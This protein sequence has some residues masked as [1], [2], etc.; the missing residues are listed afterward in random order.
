MW[1]NAEI[2]ILNYVVDIITTLL[3]RVNDS[4][5]TLQATGVALLHTVVS[6]VV[7]RKIR[8]GRQEH[9]RKATVYWDITSALSSDA[10]KK[11]VYQNIARLS[12]STA[13]TDTVY[14]FQLGCNSSLLKLR[15]PAMMPRRPDKFLLPPLLL[16]QRFHLDGGYSSVNGAVTA[17]LTIRTLTHEWDEM[18]SVHDFLKITL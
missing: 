9:G 2:F 4:V 3:W 16:T 5:S 11:L 13:D 17:P 7:R 8:C 15:L 1:V 12:G 6:T 18:L 14:P 10:L